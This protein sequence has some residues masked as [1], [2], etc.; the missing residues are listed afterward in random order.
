MKK[1]SKM[2]FLAAILYI[3]CLIL[4][5]SSGQYLSSSY[6]ITQGNGSGT[7]DICVYAVHTREINSLVECALRCGMN[8]LCNAFDFCLADGLY[9]CRFCYGHANLS[10]TTTQYEFY[11][12]TTVSTTYFT[13]TVT[14]KLDR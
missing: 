5:H 7:K 1:E 8:L 3:H 2:K 4:T 9:T 13:E 14:L 10:N 12:N 11:G 6:F